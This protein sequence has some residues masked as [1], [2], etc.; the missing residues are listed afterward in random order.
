M[1]H[2]NVWPGNKKHVDCHL[3]PHPDFGDRVGSI[4][5][6]GQEWGKSQF[7]KREVLLLL[8]GNREVVE[9]TYK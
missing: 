7:P 5:V 9:I 6:C 8:L 3:W 1:F 2:P 4:I